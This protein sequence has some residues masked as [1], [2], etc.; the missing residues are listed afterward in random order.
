MRKFRNPPSEASGQLENLARSYGPSLRSFF[1]RRVAHAEEA[2]DMTQD[3]LVRLVRHH[4]LTDVSHLGAY[5]FQ[6]AANIL[7]DRKRREIT[8]AA[9]AHQQI[10]E[11]YVDDAAFTPERVL[12]GHEAIDRLRS[13]LLEL[14]ER[15]REVFF[16][17]RIEQMPYAEIADR[18]GISLSAVNKHM[19]KAMIF[20][21]ARCRD[22]GE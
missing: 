4:S 5:I 21:V 12:M 1:Q 13:G 11:M 15:T 8:R 17:G 20:L 3:V 22:E 6:I 16:L 9:D 7:R 14:P 10:D 19:A 2:E 18:L